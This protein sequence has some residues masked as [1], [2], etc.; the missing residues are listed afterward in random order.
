[1]VV[2]GRNAVHE[3]VRG[4][5]KVRQ[6][7][8]SGAAARDEWLAQLHPAVASDHE[9][10]ELCGSSDHQ[11]VCAEVA[12][13]RYAEPPSLLSDEDALVVALDEVQDPRNLGAVIRV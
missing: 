2:Y 12:P 6:V 9:I 10:E 11:G 3:A 13:Y 5:R 4:P 7:W 8:A 1:M